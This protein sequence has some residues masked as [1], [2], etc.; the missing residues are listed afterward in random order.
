LVRNSKAKISAPANRDYEYRLRT[1]CNGG[2]ESAFSSV[3]GFSIPGE[4]LQIASSRSADR[5]E[6]D[7]EI[8]NIVS[9]VAI[10]PNPFINS[11][12]LNYTSK[13]EN[14]QVVIFHISG[15]KVLQQVLAKDISKH[16]LDVS[17]LT[18]GLYM[19]SIQEEGQQVVNQRIVKQTK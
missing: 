13:S 9:T 4:N 7:L 3:F 14:T 1:I 17:D 10:T 8:A 15:K 6:A 5:F 2:E 16:R 18:S 19:L 11:L 12:E